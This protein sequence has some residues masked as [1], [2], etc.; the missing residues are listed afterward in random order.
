MRSWVTA[1][2]LKTSF[3]LYKSMFCKMEHDPPC[4]RPCP[5]L[6]GFAA[7]GGF[8]PL[9]ALFAS[10]GRAG[11]R[12][13]P[14]T[15][16][17]PA[18]WAHPDVCAASSHQRSFLCKSLGQR[19]G[20]PS[21]AQLAIAERGCAAGSAL[22]GNNGASPYHP[23][24]LPTRVET[25]LAEDDIAQLCHHLLAHRH[26]EGRHRQEAGFQQVLLPTL[27]G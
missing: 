18:L 19:V 6:L 7:V 11:S 12:P 3:T 5:A 4:P 22:L 20:L 16:E 13:C 8:L 27:R 24:S 9:Q 26:L 15:L 14:E 17:P 25:V 23:P 21:A 10:C 2:N 1:F